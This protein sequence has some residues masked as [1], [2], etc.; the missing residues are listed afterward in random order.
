M[1]VSPSAL[2]R[3]LSPA[4]LVLLSFAGAVVVASAVLSLPGMEAPGTPPIGFVD[5]F[6]TAASAVCITGL[7]TVDTAS[8]WSLLGQA[9]ILVFVQLGGLGIMT[10][11][12]LL[13]LLV[14]GRFSVRGRMTL[15][16]TLGSASAADLRRL[17][18]TVFV[19]T[20]VIEAVG[21]AA[22]AARFALEMPPG[23]ALWFGLFHAVAAFNQAGFA[24][25]PD[26][27]ARYVGDP[28]VNV[29]VTALVV[30][31][32]L[33]F[34]VIGEFWHRRGAGRGAKGLSLHTKV[35]LATS[36]VLLA[37]GAL[38]FALL[39]WRHA[40]SGLSWPAKVM[41]AWFQAVAPRSAGLS[42][43][44]Y[45]Q[46]SNP[47]LLFTIVLMFIGAAPGSTGGGVKVTTA[48]I[49]WGLARSQFAG[50]ERVHLFRR[51]VPHDAVARGVTIAASA[52][53]TVVLLTLV[54]QI[55]EARGPVSD[56]RRSL[57]LA[58]LFEAV[59]ALG[60]VGLSLGVT[61]ELSAA[62]KVLIALAM[63]VGRV[64]PLTLTLGLSRPT[65]GRFE[66]SEAPVIV[67]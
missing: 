44:D 37:V 42:T 6:F 4:Q 7:T 41:A 56:A 51:A 23:R 40:L 26:S 35:V 1:R 64:G 17:V 52:V 2:V 19:S 43:L 8:R 16:D 47:T 36:G 18:A 11:S 39:E 62:G 29:V 3:R 34:L 25:F 67:G 58:L 13:V 61:P 22:L 12:T 66:Y 54:L 9:T 46:L 10:C 21:A 27:L 55:T 5:A 60:T 32:G 38:G 63:Y 59:S 20:L 48:A 24:L 45:T 14:R 53:A 33:G 28:V 15:Q 50:E 31:G 57:F 49:V 65:R 30:L